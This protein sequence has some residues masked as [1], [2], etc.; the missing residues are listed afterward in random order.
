MVIMMCGTAPAQSVFSN[1]F[2]FVPS[3]K[4]SFEKPPSIWHPVNMNT[5]AQYVLFHLH[6]GCLLKA[7][8]R[9]YLY[10]NQQKVVVFTCVW[11]ERLFL[12]RGVF[13][14]ECDQRALVHD[15]DSSL[16]NA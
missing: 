11:K 14:D 3:E 2:C 4:P 9:N 6:H 1:L 10:I 7:S 12:S 8:I 13:G 16:S 15:L 5:A